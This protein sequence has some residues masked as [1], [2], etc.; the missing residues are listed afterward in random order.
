LLRTLIA[1]GLLGELSQV[2][3]VFVTHVGGV[4]LAN[5]VLA[6]EFSGVVT[7]VMIDSE[8]GF[9]QARVKH[10]AVVVVLMMRVF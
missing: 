5:S 4:D 3:V 8:E 6:R 7:T 9:N 2:N 10:S 1:L